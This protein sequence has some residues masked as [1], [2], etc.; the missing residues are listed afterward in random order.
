MNL[1]QHK[2]LRLGGYD[3]AAVGCYFVTVVTEGRRELFGHIADGQLMLTAQERW[4]K[5][6][7][8]TWKLVSKDWK[9]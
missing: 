2:N 5:N 4:L 3:Y 7:S 1:K 6:V 8:P 9:C